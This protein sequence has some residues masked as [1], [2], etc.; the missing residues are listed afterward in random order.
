MVQAS[1]E[2]DE[3]AT[4]VSV[5]GVGACDLVSRTAM[6]CGL[7]DTEKCD[8]LLPVV[9]LFSSDTST[10]LWDDEVG[11]THG[12]R[13]GEGGEQGDAL[14]P[15]N[16]GQHGALKTVARG[17]RKERVFAFLDDLYVI[18]RQTDC[19]QSTEAWYGTTPGFHHDGKAKVAVVRRGDTSLPTPRQ[20]LL[21]FGDTGHD[22]F[23]REQ[24]RSRREKHDVRLQRIRPNLHTN[25]DNDHCLTQR[26]TMDKNDPFYN[27]E[28]A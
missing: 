16:F 21:I 8:R 1:T 18:C 4:I 5:G 13:Q 28:W 20:G 25:A 17:W 6:L 27:V 7:M 26:A 11:G 23:V 2:F 22:D 19:K 3:S 14:M 9:R 15:L 24:L 12:I 10:F